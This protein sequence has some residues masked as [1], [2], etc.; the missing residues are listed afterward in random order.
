MDNQKLVYTSAPHLKMESTVS[1]AM[2]DVIIALIPVCLVAIYFF[3][4]YAVFM[5]AVCMATAAITELIFRKAM[6][7][8]SSL[9]DYSAL[10]T[11]LLVALCLPA[12]TAWWMGA[13]A[14]F[15][16]IGVAKE[17]M[18]GLGWNR[19]NPALFGRVAIIVLAPIITLLGTNFLSLSDINFGA[20]DVM[21]RATPL[22]MLKQGM[23]MPS[24]VKLFFA[25]PGGALGEVSPFAL[26]LG[27]AY[28]FYRGHIKWQIP[29]SIL[30][31]VFVLALITGQ[32]PLYH[33]FTGGM[34][35]GALFMATD[36]VTCPITNKGKLIFGVAIGALIMI[37]R[38]G[39]APT[40]GVAFSILIMN[41]FVP[42][43][44]RVTKRA[45]YIEPGIRRAVEIPGQERATAK[46]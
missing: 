34:F 11:G 24:L 4:F 21:T 18:G 10:L 20:V 13:I 38:V 31:T 9:N 14:T 33:L 19:F 43:I 6:K 30:A 44:D 16:A 35:L 27:A 26:L 41:A 36:W 23:E 3:K 40:E 17:L 29:V 22:A 25:F 8:E 37:F 39:L 46:S 45:S 7:K 1:Q 28:L 2:R 12:T 15:I 32:N 5:I 42:L